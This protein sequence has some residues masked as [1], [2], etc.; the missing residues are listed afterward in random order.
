VI[1]HHDRLHRFL[2]SPSES[3]GAPTL[4]LV[5]DVVPAESVAPVSAVPYSIHYDDL[6]N[7]FLADRVMT[8][9]EGKAFLE[10]AFRQ[11]THYMP[12]HYLRR[13]AAALSLEDA[14]SLLND[15]RIQSR[16]RQSMRARLQGEARV[17][18]LGAVADPLP[19]HVGALALAE[20]AS[21]AVTQKAARSLLLRGL[22][23][24]PHG[25]SS[26]AENLDAPR[27]FEAIT[28]LSPQAIR[29][30]SEPLRGM[31]SSLFLSE[32]E[33]WPSTTRSIFRKAVAHLDDVLFEGAGP[34]M[35]EV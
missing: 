16:M 15:L 29:E 5:G 20:K 8:P 24:D 12:L 18:P 23:T 34:L 35:Q 31:L 14:I 2:Y 1:L 19:P 6:I 7:S 30:H 9:A 27:L 4:R 21:A 13:K 25:V 11:D 33:N 28:H 32:Y 10:E 26:I 17:Q 22:T 3:A